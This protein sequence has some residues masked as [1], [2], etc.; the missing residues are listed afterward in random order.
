MALIVHVSA[1]AAEPSTDVVVK[2]ESVQAERF[3]IHWRERVRR[4]NAIDLG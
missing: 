4:A 3:S 2:K 1:L